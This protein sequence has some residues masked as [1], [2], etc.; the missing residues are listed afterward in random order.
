MNDNE[1]RSGNTVQQT[2]LGPEVCRCR[3]LSGART[4]RSQ[5]FLFGW[6][7]YYLLYPVVII[8]WIAFMTILF[9]LGLLGQLLG[10]SL[11][12]MARHGR[13]SLAGVGTLVVVLY[14]VFCWFTYVWPR[15]DY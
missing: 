15:G 2:D 5:G 12:T 8:P 6:L 10:H 11:E 4:L 13:S 14:L 3:R 7:L 1:Q 9:P